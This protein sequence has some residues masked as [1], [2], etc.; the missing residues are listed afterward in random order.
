MFVKKVVLFI[1][2]VSTFSFVACNNSGKGSKST[3]DSVNKANQPV[4]KKDAQFMTNAAEINME[5]IALGNLAQQ[6]ATSQAVKNFGKMLVDDHSQLNTKVQMLA[7]QKNIA[8]PDSATK[9]IKNAEEELRQTDQ[10]DQDFINKMINGHKDAIDLFQRAIKEVSDSDIK[11][12]ATSA[13]PQLQTHL[14]S[15]QV[16]E[17]LLK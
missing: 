1:I 8:L 13:L 6:R 17:K 3:A 7:S 16:I 14:D 9:T 12:L 2:A 5:E 15:A 10:F 4:P 11:A